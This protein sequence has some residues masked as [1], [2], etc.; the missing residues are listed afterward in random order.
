MEAFMKAARAPRADKT[1]IKLL[2]VKDGMIEDSSI[3]RLPDHLRPGDLLVVNDA[4][5]MPASL[6][7]RDARNNQMEL[8]LTTQLDERV[9]QAAV[10]GAGD[11]RTP[12][13]DRPLA[14]RFVEGEEIM[15]ASD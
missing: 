13:E 6:P 2:V 11:W 14:P 7:A 3:E 15:I 8:R 10:L 9:W 1:S 12:T 4:A 5:T